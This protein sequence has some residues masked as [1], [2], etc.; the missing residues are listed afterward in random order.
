[1]T[2]TKFK[3]FADF[4]SFHAHIFP[5]LFTMKLDNSI[6]SFCK[7][8][9]YDRCLRRKKTALGIGI[10]TMLGMEHDCSVRDR[11]KKFHTHYE[12]LVAWDQCQYEMRLLETILMPALEKIV[13]GTTSAT[14]A[15]PLRDSWEIIERLLKDP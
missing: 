5:F 13:S 15:K 9:F 3:R 11:E 12:D 7:R 4:A 1:M 8:C 10:N 14:S 6:K 2:T